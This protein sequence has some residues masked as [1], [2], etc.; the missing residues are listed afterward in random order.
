MRS[1]VMVLFATV[2]VCRVAL[3]GE[4]APPKFA[5]KPTATRAGDKMKVDFAVDRE[6]DVAVFIENAQGKVVRHLAAGVLG[7]NPPPPLK[8]GSLEQSV[9]WD[10]KADY[11]RSTDLTAG[12]S[13]GPGA[14]AGREIAFAWPQAV[15]VGNGHAY[16]GDRINRRIVRV[17]LAHA[18]EEA[19][20]IK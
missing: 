2:A 7:K 3:A 15:A 6:T 18:A 1:I 20:L 9:E 14:A 4:A 11:G 17:K 19:C 16:V 8:A 13:A 5:K 10:G 12:K